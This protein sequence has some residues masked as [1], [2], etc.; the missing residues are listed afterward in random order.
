MNVLHVFFLR[1]TF[2]AGTAAA[3]LIFV[4]WWSL[5]RFYK[6]V[7][8]RCKNCGWLWVSRVHKIRFSEDEELPLGGRRKKLHWFFRRLARRKRWWIRRV[9]TETF[10]VCKC[11]RP[12]ESVKRGKGPISVV[13]L[14]WVILTDPEQLDLDTTLEGV[15]EQA[16]L[17]WCSR[18]SLEKERKLDS[19]PFRPIFPP[20]GDET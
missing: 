6:Q 7:G 14:F 18:D 12:Y 1:H 5:Y 13:H 16:T 10:A 8:R 3:V 4:I 20:D 15:S 9:K 17:D 19:P 2:W 11:T